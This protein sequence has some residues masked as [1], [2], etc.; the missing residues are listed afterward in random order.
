MASESTWECFADQMG[1]LTIA[2][3]N[4]KELQENIM[5]R[6]SC[7][8]ENINER[9]NDLQARMDERLL[10]LQARMEERQLNLETQLDK[11]L[12][13]ISLNAEEGLGA[14]NTSFIEENSRRYVE[15]DAVALRRVSSNVVDNQFAALTIDG[16][17]I[18]Q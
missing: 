3:N 9:Y 14:I 12:Q 4:A 7:C 11:I 10:N 2:V 1:K 13:K 16:K 5:K 15:V 18:H 6:V 8:E 17:F